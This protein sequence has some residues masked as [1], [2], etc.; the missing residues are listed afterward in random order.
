MINDAELQRLRSMLVTDV[1]AD[2]R[3]VE[4]H[5]LQMKIDPYNGIRVTW[6][7]AC[8]ALGGHHRLWCVYWSD[9]AVVLWCGG[10]WRQISHSTILV[11]MAGFTFLTDPIWS[12]R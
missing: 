6:V 2:L 9:V 11:Q 5:D 7:R 1:G 10:A 4:E 12:D 8:A 3:A